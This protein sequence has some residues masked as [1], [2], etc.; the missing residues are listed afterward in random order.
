M[1]SHDSVLNDLPL[2]PQ[3]PDKND[4]AAIYTAMQSPELHSMLPATPI[5]HY[6]SGNNTDETAFVGGELQP[7]VMLPSTPPPV[8]ERADSEGSVGFGQAG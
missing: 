2:L 4:S 8:R 5:P 7:R 3:T 1:L 6:P